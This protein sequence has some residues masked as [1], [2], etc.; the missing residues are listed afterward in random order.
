MENEKKNY[1]RYALYSI[2]VALLIA[3]AWYLFSQPGGS[4]T[5][6]EHVE[7]GLDDIGRE[8]QEAKQSIGAIES[9]IT[10]GQRRTDSIA[11]SIERSQSTAS[12]I[13]DNNDRAA[14][15]IGESEKAVDRIAS[16]TDAIATANSA[17]VDR[18][19]AAKEANERAAAS[20]GDAAQLC[21]QCTELN[22]QSGEI[23]ARYT[24]GVQ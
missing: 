10:D 16:S 22:R 17:A 24:A 13:A 8:Q 18:A 2:G 3:G 21:G 1:I 4:R 12:A 23:L 15:R 19:I 11:D 6:S 14:E 9:G 7:T 20:L 5:A